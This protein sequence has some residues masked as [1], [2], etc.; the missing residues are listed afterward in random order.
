M[1]PT[2]RIATIHD[3]NHIVTRTSEQFKELNK[4]IGIPGF[5][6]TDPEMLTMHIEK[7]IQD[8]PNCD[9][10][11]LIVDGQTESESFLCYLLDKKLRFGEIVFAYS[12]E[13]SKDQMSELIDTVLVEMHANGISRMK[14]EIGP[15]DVCF[16]QVLREKG[17]RK[18]SEYYSILL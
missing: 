3:I 8:Y 17:A 12:Y 10:T 18:T 5:Y 1:M 7:R 14:F 13:N 4:T 11:Y 9:F 16:A 2:V 15:H 6:K